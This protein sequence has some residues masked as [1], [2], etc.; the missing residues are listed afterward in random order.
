ML[1]VGCVEFEVNGCGGEV[2]WM[3][4]CLVLG[5]VGYVFVGVGDNCM[6]IIDLGEDNLILEDFDLFVCLFEVLCYLILD[7]DFQNL[8]SYVGVEL[9]CYGSDLLLICVFGG[10]LICVLY[11]CLFGE[12]QFL[13]VS[14][15][16]DL[17]CLDVYIVWNLVWCIMVVELVQVVCFSLSYFYVQF[18]DSVGLILY[19]YLF[20]V[21]FDCV[22]WL[23]WESCLFLVWIV[24]ECGFFS[25]SVLIMVMCCYLGLMLKLLCKG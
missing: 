16:F 3:C 8:F 2:C 4:V 18:K 23:L 17:E 5:E 12:Q 7:V 1:L 9:V 20:K 10:V 11:L 24:E 14:G 6:L 15:L 13:V 19:Q 22:V 25:Q 21:C